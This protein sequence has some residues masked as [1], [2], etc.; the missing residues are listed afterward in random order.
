LTPPQALF[1]DASILI[2]LFNKDRSEMD[3]ADQAFKYADTLPHAA[4][5]VVTPCL[6]ELFFKTR[7]ILAPK[8]IQY[9]FRLL[10][11]ELYPTTETRE[12]ELFKKY[13]EST[14]KKEYDFA[15]F[16]MCA[17]ALDFNPTEILT[18]DRDD[19]GLAMSRAHG[20]F[21]KKPHFN[22]RQFP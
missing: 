15:D 8:D 21:S 9:N 20:T 12:R 22:I 16:Y 18:L 1:F 5:L 11:I 7:K 17:V 14:Y 3:L 4:R 10:N 13:C 2:G 6:V 19:I